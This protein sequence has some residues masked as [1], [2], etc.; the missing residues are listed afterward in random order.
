MSGVPVLVSGVPLTMKNLSILGM[1]STVTRREVMGL[2]RGL[3]SDRIS[4]LRN[5]LFDECKRTDLCEEGDE[6]RSRLEGRGRRPLKKRLC[7][8]VWLLVRHIRH[9]APLISTSLQ[10]TARHYRMILCSNN[11]P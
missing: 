10:P 4:S 11:L 5:A 7:E 3:A 8:D 6:I 1:G 2:L 9:L